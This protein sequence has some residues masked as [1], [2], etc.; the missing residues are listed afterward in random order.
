MTTKKSLFC[1]VMVTVVVFKSTAAQNYGS[2]NFYS[3]NNIESYNT[4]QYNNADHIQREYNSNTFEFKLTTIAVYISDDIKFTENMAITSALGIVKYFLPWIKFEMVNNIKDSNIIL[5]F[6]NKPTSGV[7]YHHS[8]ENYNHT[9][10]KHDIFLSQCF[11]C[12]KNNYVGS[13]QKYI[14][15]AL[16]LQILPSSTHNSI[17]APESSYYD[18]P[19]YYGDVEYIALLHYGKAFYKNVLLSTNA[20]CNFLVSP[21]DDDDS[22]QINTREETYKLFKKYQRRYENW[23]FIITSTSMYDD[24]MFMYSYLKNYNMNCRYHN[25]YRYNCIITTK[26]QENFNRCNYIFLKNHNNTTNYDETT[27]ALDYTEIDYDNGK[28]DEV[29]IQTTPKIITTTTKKTTPKTTEKNTP[30]TT[31]TPTEKITPKTTAS[32]TKNPAIKTTTPTVK[33]QTT[34][35]TTTTSKTTPQIISTKNTTIKPTP[36]T[37]TPLKTTLESSTSKSPVIIIDDIGSGSYENSTDVNLKNEF[38]HSESEYEYYEYDYD[39]ATHSKTTSNDIIITDSKGQKTTIITK[40]SDNKNI[41]IINNINK[42]N[43]ENNNN[44]K[45][46]SITNKKYDTNNYTII[47]YGDNITIINNESHN[48]ICDNNIKGM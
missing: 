29:L 37:I 38:H 46:V 15:L 7:V 5:C 30:K 19:I 9:N 16:G 45:N 22:T 47:N 27:P 18:Y 25:L 42:T 11:N 35:T 4:N 3:P 32:T 36:K 39:N 17:A 12:D 10:M 24:F 14:L 13:I 41:T 44:A 48:K 1:L 34:T 21:Y 28:N 33:F 31:A 8:L 43:D 2:S 26:Y 23:G 20:M 6:Y 40:I